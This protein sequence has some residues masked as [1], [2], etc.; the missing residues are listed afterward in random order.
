VDERREP[1]HDRPQRRSAIVERIELGRELRDR[2]D[3][4]LQI[5]LL[6]D[7]R[8]LVSR[9]GRDGLLQ[10][11]RPTGEKSNASWAVGSF[12]SAAARPSCSGR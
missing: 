2:G 7:A 12:P 8:D 10:R 5:R 6:F 3:G 11:G 9:A 1:L 4:G